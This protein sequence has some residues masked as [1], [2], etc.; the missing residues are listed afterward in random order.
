MN[1]FKNVFIYI[2]QDVSVGKGYL[3]SYEYFFFM[4]NDDFR[5]ELFENIKFVCI[6]WNNI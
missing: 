1:I 6:F 2:F 5:V 3:K 4:N